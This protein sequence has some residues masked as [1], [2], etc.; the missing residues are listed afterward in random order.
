MLVVGAN[1]TVDLESNAVVLGNVQRADLLEESLLNLVAGVDADGADTDGSEVGRGVVVLPVHSDGGA[2]L[3]NGR[4]D[5]LGD[6][7]GGDDMDERQ[8][9]LTEQDDGHRFSRVPRGRRRQQRGEQ[10]CLR[11][12][13]QE[14][15]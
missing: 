9:I 2:D 12:L 8:E 15:R 4:L 3:P 13:L 7:K 14:F 11:A 6:L 1:V 5:G 10:R